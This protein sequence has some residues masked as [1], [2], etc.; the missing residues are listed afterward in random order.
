M[1]VNQISTELSNLIRQTAEDC[2]MQI[3]EDYSGRGMF[4]RTCFGL[5]YSGTA[6]QLCACFLRAMDDDGTG[7]AQELADLLD[8]MRTDSMGYDTIYYFPGWELEESEDPK[9]EDWDDEED[10]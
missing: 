1:F 8:D 3:R 7:T 6:G 4:G 10:E 5:V 9:D 2:N